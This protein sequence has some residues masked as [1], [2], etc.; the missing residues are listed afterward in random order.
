MS[1]K[2]FVAGASGFIGKALIEALL[3]DNLTHESIHIVAASRK[4]RGSSHPRLEWKKCDLFSLKELN[5]AIAGCDA[6]YYLVHSMLPS[7]SLSQGEFYDFD[8][9]IADNFKRAATASGIKKIIYLGGLIPS[10]IKT[11]SWHLKSR[12]EVEQTLRQAAPQG[13][14]LRAG[15]I[16]GREGSSFTILKKLVHRLPMMILPA[17]TR[18]QMEPIALQDAI[19]ILVRSLFDPTLEGKGFD[20]GGREK[21]T[22]RDLIQ[23]TAK[24]LHI[25]NISLFLNLIP[26]GLSR[27]WVSF[28]TGTPKSL[29][30]PLVL[31]LKYPMLVQP[32]REWP[33]PEDIQISLDQALTE[34]IESAQVAALPKV[35]LENLKNVRSVQRLTLPSGLTAEQ[36]SQE[37][38]NW[39]PRY[40]R[41]M[42]QVKVDPNPASP[43]LVFRML[44]LTLLILEKSVERST[45]D[46]QLLYIKGGLLSSKNDRGRLEFREVLDRKYV[47]AAI[48][49]YRPA[50]PW[51]IYKITQAKLH[52]W[53]MN[54]FGKHLERL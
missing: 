32:G 8:L 16:V 30:Y 11:L 4:T 46:R 24:V 20:I 23:K 35:K 47:M 34:A 48:H 53:V 41:P 22:Y 3:S 18:T 7:A 40:F 12:L 19:R 33:H 36:V 26:L 21:I 9:I 39:I 54:A 38:F 43:R 29:V 52:L 6:A 42:I 5:E 45:V 51:F 2:V 44:G 14:M 13:V 1:K 37:Y 28:I 15:L 27:L 49:E 25:R 31:S 50:L 17:W 10:E